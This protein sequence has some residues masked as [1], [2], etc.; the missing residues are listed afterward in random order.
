MPTLQICDPTAPVPVQ[1]STETS[2]VTRLTGARVAVV[3]NGWMSMSRI[4]KLLAER[5]PADYAVAS[6]QVYVVEPNGGA[7]EAVLQKIEKDADLAVV[8][9]ANCGGCT[10]WSV[11]NQVELMRRG[12]YSVLLVTERYKKLAEV[13]RRGR[14][15]SDAPF[16]VLPITEET[17]YGNEQ[18]MDQIAALA[19]RGAVD[20]LAVRRAA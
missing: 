3:N 10:S 11:Q 1:S 14:G 4:A 19:L 8:G 16:V 9:L 15:M 12:V 13:I 5:L 20:L 7:T 6:V 2:P 18:T 17:E